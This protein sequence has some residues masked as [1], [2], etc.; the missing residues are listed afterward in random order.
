[1]A[2]SLATARGYFVA[3][4]TADH[5]L[6]WW[7]YVLLFG[8]AALGGIGYVAGYPDSDHRDRAAAPAATAPDPAGVTEAD[9]YFAPEP[10]DMPPVTE[11]SHP[12]PGPVI[13]DRWHPFTWTGAADE[14]L[15]ALA[16]YCQRISVSG[17]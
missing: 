8:L 1:M 9:E 16:A 13:T 10:A 7:P 6:P 4:I 3:M 5:P 2:V 17:H 15:A 12:P 14:I 11:A